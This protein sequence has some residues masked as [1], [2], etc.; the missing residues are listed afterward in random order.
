MTSRVADRPTT[1]DPSPVPVPVLALVATSL[2]L[3][4]LA[5]RQPAVVAIAPLVIV[6]LVTMLSRPQV[7]TWLFLALVYLNVPVI[8]TKLYGVPYLIGA[9]VIGLLL[10]PLVTY[11]LRR[12]PLI[13]TSTFWWMFAFLGTLLVSAVFAQDRPASLQAIA[14]LLTEGLL[15][16]VLITNVIRTPGALRAAM[17]VLIIAGGVMGGVSLYQEQTH[18][19]TNN[20]GGFAQVN[21]GASN[22]SPLEESTNSVRPRLAGPVGEKNRYAQ[23]LLVL[24]PLALFRF[25]REQS[26]MLR[27][28]ALVATFLILAG[29]FLTFSRGGAVSVAAIFG[30]LVVFR[31][32][33]A[34][35]LLISLV[36]LVLAVIV[37][38]PTYLGRLES[39]G[40]LEALLSSDAGDIPDGA[41]IGRTTAQLA[42]LQTFVTHP[43]VGAGPGNFF[44]VYSQPYANDLGIGFYEEARRAHNLY[45]ETAADDGILGLVAMLGIMLSTVIGLGRVRRMWLPENRDRAD[46]AT[47]LMFAVIGYM[48]SA[49]FLHLSYERYFYLLIA[50]GNVGIIVLQREWADH[51]LA[52]QARFA[53]QMA[54]G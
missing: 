13:V 25:W 16:Y 20:Y 14:V 49:V 3:C 7:A 33:G 50:L 4:L 5:L 2:T 11:V 36:A 6:A 21:F 26:P 17:W 29:V 48:V 19:Y 27:V 42:A 35:G 52:G 44:T 8:G 37:V 34:R 41:I 18:T 30:L 47:A 9:S 12:E 38:A 45:L 28:L 15:L 24:F 22:T 31:Y 40:G 53:S 54:V 10:I 51:R 46:L 43:L 1:R 32:I 23:V 39:L